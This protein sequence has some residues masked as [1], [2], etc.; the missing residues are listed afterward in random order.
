M[1]W[2]DFGG[3]RSHDTRGKNRPTERSLPIERTTRT[4]RDFT[5]LLLDGVYRLAAETGRPP[6]YQITA[7]STMVVM[8]V[9]LVRVDE[10]YDY[11]TTF[12]SAMIK[13]KTAIEQTYF[14]CITM[15]HFQVCIRARMHMLTIISEVFV[16]FC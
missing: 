3:Q 8:F 9:V 6:T 10:F 1:I 13:L 14:P 16:C 11:G 12:V 5:Y 4:L 15:E 2:L 7:V